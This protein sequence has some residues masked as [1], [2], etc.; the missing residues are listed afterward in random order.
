MCLKCESASRRFQ[1][2]EGPIGWTFVSSSTAGGQP[3]PAGRRQGGQLQETHP[4]EQEPPARGA[5][6]DVPRLRFQNGHCSCRRSVQIQILGRFRRIF[7]VQIISIQLA[8]D[9]D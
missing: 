3:S 4:T 7:I 6:Q 5:A 1:L 8:I 2:G 9:S